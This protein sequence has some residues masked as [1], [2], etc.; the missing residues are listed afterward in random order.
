[1]LVCFLAINSRAQ[2]K[3]FDL[4]KKYSVAELVEDIDYTEKYLLKFHPDP[5]RYTTRDSLHAF[6]SYI[7]SRIDTPL[8][9]MQFRF[10]MKQILAQIGCGHTDVAS[11]KAY[12]KALE[13]VHRPILPLNTVLT[14]DDKLIVINNLS[15]DSTINA[16]DEITGIDGRPV[17]TI[18]KTIYSTFTTDG[19]NQTYKKRGIRYEWFKYYYSFCFGFRLQ[20]RVAIKN[21]KGSIITHTLQA[22][23]S[24]KD[25]L[26]LPKTDSLP[27]IYK[28]AKCR[29]FTMNDAKP[30]AV[31]DVDAFGGK[32]WYRFFRKSFKDINRKKIEHLVIDLRDNGGGSISNGMNMLSYMIHKP[33]LIPFDRKPNLIAFNPRLKMGLASRI[34]PLLFTFLMPELP[35]HGRLRHY[36]IGIPKLRHSYKGTVYV[37]TNGKSFSMSAIAATYLKYKANARVIGDETGGNIAGSNAVINGTLILPNSKIRIYVPVYH[38]YHDIKVENKAHGL[39]PDYPT[40]YDKES[41]LKGRDLDLEKV[42]ELVN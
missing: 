35:R 38:I 6:F 14:G 29:Y 16:G 10:Y 4:H 19:H 13:T 32:K 12:A 36:F 5:Y 7:K 40:L 34:T 41:L 31:I 20:Y 23:P 28:S 27:V 11:S 18:L 8:T 9:E 30:I 1:M 2:K 3:D 26:I 33:F 24:N 22:I 42:K 21:E 39:M 15:A 25:T 17:N 37:L